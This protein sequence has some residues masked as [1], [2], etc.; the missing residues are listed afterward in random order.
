MVLLRN[1]K[2]SS[3]IYATVITATVL[4]IACG[5][6][7]VATSIMH[8]DTLE[9]IYL[10]NVRPLDDLRKIQLIFRELEYRM[11]GALADVVAPIGS[12]EHM[13][14]AIKQIDS[15]W[16][17]T[18][19][20][21]RSEK[22]L[23]EEARTFDKSYGEF[24]K[25]AV[26]FEK[27]YYDED[28]E[29]IEEHIDEWYDYKR[30]IFKSIDGMAENQALLVKDFYDRQ[31]AFTRKSNALLVPALILPILLLLLLSLIIVR[32][33]K[34]SIDACSSA[35]RVVA[36]GDLTNK[37]NLD[38]KDEMGRMASELN[39][40]LVNLQ[41]AFRHI[42]ESVQVASEQ[43]RKLSDSS[44]SLL[45]DTERQNS[46]ATQVATS[47]TEMSQ[48]IL[49][50]ASNASVASKAANK[51]FETA[52]EGEDV[53]KSTIQGITSLARSIEGATKTVDILESSSQDIG[54]I[55]LLIHDIA[56]QTNLLALN[57]AIEAARAGEQG[58]GFAVVADEV[59]KLAEK[60]ANATSDIANKIDSM[61][62]AT[63]EFVVMIDQSKDLTEN[64]V[65]SATEAGNALH[66]VV[67]SSDKVMDMV[68][69]IATSA[70][71]QSAAA[72]QVSHSMEE[73]SQV[74]R[75]TVRL[76]GTVK[77]SALELDANSQLVREQLSKFKT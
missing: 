29:A 14:G 35:A 36:Q 70:E 32:S 12:G 57:A 16:A 23:S 9:E 3:K 7:L 10:N 6:F 41:S 21:V 37:I 22:G 33:I 38:S 48:T 75:N 59:R 76:A 71:E 19:E 49:D 51:S 62:S 77:E 65:T 74:I 2:I 39:S 58:R 13:K 72:E 24:K 40:M 45:D 53:V 73:I 68:N 61:Q 30:G 54:E 55:L 8:E 66:K 69:R 26:R 47:A 11:A 25:L 31:Q 63:R 64:S 15:L 56:D 52:K 34:N 4:L 27:A 28:L 42:S 60:T 17:D 5:T 43:S 44:K 1:L 20:L 18:K 67:E 46:Q 50:V